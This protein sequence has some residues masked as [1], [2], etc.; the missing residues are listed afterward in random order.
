LKQIN[1]E[2]GK[3][4][5]RMQEEE[6]YNGGQGSTLACRREYQYLNSKITRGREGAVQYISA[7]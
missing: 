2:K 3:K 4:Q 1:P 6:A 5:K 7:E